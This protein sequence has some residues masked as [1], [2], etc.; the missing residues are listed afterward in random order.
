M[1]HTTAT[2]PSGHIFIIGGEKADGSNTAYLEH[3]LFD[4]AGPSFKLLPADNGPPGICG[5][6]SIILPDG[7]LF[8]F[9]GY[10]QPQ[11]SLLPFSTIFTMD[12]TQSSLSWTTFTTSNSSL[13]PPR[14]AFAAALLSDG[15]ILIHGG[16]DAALQNNFDDGWIL[17]TS[18]NPMVWT[19]ISV[20][21]QL[22][23][24]RDHFAVSSGSQVIFGFGLSSIPRGYP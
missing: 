13:P 6:A 22:G 12:T 19:Q 17:D 23:A 8:V 2:V 16:S 15:N 21:S 1:Y 20:L 10:S 18:Q 14:R 9:G 11:A 4:P 3:Y 24:R 7:R 5:H